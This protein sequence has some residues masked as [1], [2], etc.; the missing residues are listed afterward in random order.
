[1]ASN[2]HRCRNLLCGMTLVLLAA[3]A[4]VAWTER[5]P[6]LA[7]LY[8]RGLV[9][10]NEVT[11]DRWVE[12]VAGL[13][14]AAVP[15]LLQALANPDPSA[16]A[17]VQAGLTRVSFE[18]GSGD[19]LRAS[20][21]IRLTRGWD[22]LSNAGKASAMELLASWFRSG[23]ETTPEL[24]SA[25]ARLLAAAARGEKT[26]VPPHA[27]ELCAALLPR[28]GGA[29][30]V[31]PGRSLT[32][33]CLSNADP[34]TRVLA[35]RLAL[36][37][38]MDLLEDVAPLLNDPSTKVRRAAVMAVG[39]AEQVV[40]DETL[41][42]CLHDSDA[43]VRR[44][45]ELALRGRG[46]RPEHIQLGRVLTDPSPVVRVQVLDLLRQTPDLDAG[47]WLRRLS[48]DPSPAVR[49][50][51]MRAMSQQCSVDLS[52]RIDQM[53]HD[54]PSPTVCLLARYYLK[55]ARPSLTAE[56]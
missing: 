15:D 42:Q 37:P 31:S 45:G 13:G 6:L 20:L 3:G 26:D 47:I 4:V 25:C 16:C 27:L 24:V 30:A 10:S 51:A 46:L 49:A 52:D 39:P 44:L 43:E 28:P 17:N 2:P 14:E 53:A 34:A 23:D 54:D 48:H 12:R 35:I 33:I 22:G 7:W 29:E 8:V 9:R 1:M 38:G 18:P 5:T 56:R 50:A 21:V 11:R 40:R 32:R 55:G 41:L 19:A 36:Y